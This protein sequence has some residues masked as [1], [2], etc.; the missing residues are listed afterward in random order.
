MCPILFF[1][2]KLCFPHFSGGAV[3]GLG[4]SFDTNI[5][6]NGCYANIAEDKNH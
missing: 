6:H 4:D 2:P 3:T 1:I 5:D